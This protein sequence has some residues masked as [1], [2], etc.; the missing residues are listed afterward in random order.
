MATSELECYALNR[1]TFTSLLGPVLHCARCIVHIASQLQMGIHFTRL[2]E[3]LLPVQAGDGN[4]HLRDGVLCA[5]Q[6]HLHQPAGACGG[7]LALRGPAQGAVQ[8]TG[9][10]LRDYPRS[11]TADKPA[12]LA[13]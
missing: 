5:G 9:V 7:P 1:A 11:K 6:G 10:L 2:T 3:R 4:R 13:S 12:C 8:L